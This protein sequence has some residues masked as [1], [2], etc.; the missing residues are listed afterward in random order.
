MQPIILLLF[1]IH[2]LNLLQDNICE[3]VTELDTC[4]V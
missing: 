2:V 1:L 3:T 4:E